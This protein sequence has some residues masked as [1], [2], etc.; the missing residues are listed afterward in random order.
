MMGPNILL[1]TALSPVEPHVPQAVLSE[2]PPVVI[3]VPG[4]HAAAAAI[5]EHIAREGME[6]VTVTTEDIKDVEGTIADRRRE[7]LAKARSLSPGKRVMLASVLA[8]MGLSGVPEGLVREVRREQHPGA[9]ERIAKAEERRKRRQARNL[10][11]S[12]RVG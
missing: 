7:L 6:G 11:N 5:R 8:S 9:D 12:G 3:S 4:N 1:D 10:R 2:Q